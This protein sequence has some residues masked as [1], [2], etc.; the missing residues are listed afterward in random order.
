MTL[1]DAHLPLSW[2]FKKF[3]KLCKNSQDWRAIFDSIRPITV[4]LWQN[5][6]ASKKQRFMRHCFR[7]WN[8]HRHRC[9]PQQ[10]Q[11]ILDLI[12]IKKVIL[13]KEKIKSQKYIE[14][15]GFDFALENQLLSNLLKNKVIKKDEINL[16][17][18]SNFDN[19][20]II[21]ANNFGS[22]FETTAIAEL[23]AQ[24]FCDVFW[25]F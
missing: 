17:F 25:C 8:T 16:G 14:C 2:L 18:Q 4:Q 11:K 1:Q 22:F 15:L 19:F 7:L 10:Y 5:F 9:P 23:R 13:T 3:T 6:D 20:K 21:G 12:K 24:A